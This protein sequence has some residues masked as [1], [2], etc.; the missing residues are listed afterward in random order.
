M[1]AWQAILPST[2][3]STPKRRRPHAILHRTTPILLRHRSA[4]PLHVS[5]YPEPGRGGA[6]APGFARGPG[7]VPAGHRPLPEGCGGGGRMYLHL[8]LAGRSVCPR[9]HCLR[10]GA[11]ALHEGD[12]RRQSKER[13]DRRHSAR[14]R[15]GTL[16]QAYVYPPRMRATRDLLR[17]RTIPKR[18]FG[19]ARCRESARS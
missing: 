4:R 2:V 6:A 14:W 18:S 5:V 17:R 8:V 10:A 19:C 15:G 12:P 13:Q 7:A 3:R 16:A 1:R 9:G 11:C